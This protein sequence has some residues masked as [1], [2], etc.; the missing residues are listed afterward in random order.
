MAK[1][2]DSK[3]DFEFDDELPEG[4]DGDYTALE[5]SDQESHDFEDEDEDTDTDTDEF[6][7]ATE[8]EYYL[9]DGGRVALVDYSGAEEG[10]YPD[11]QVM[12]E[13]GY[14][15]ECPVIDILTEGDEISVDEAVRRIRKLG[16]AI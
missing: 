8:I 6:G 15:H 16:G 10:E 13:D 9:L 2:D 4:L 1:E 5:P 3:P 14:W 7:T 11:G 12:D